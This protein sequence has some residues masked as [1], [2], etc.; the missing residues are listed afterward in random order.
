M[1]VEHVIVVAYTVD[2]LDAADVDELD[3]ELEVV[4]E[5]EDVDDDLEC[6]ECKGKVH[7]MEIQM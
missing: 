4:I 7:M 5:G 3:C 6:E 2:V 1:E